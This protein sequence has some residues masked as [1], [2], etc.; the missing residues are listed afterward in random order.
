MCSLESMSDYMVVVRD[1]AILFLQPDV[2]YKMNFD[3]V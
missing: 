2:M 3:K 1:D